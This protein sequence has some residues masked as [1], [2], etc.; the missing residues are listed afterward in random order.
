MFLT[1]SYYSNGS[2][3]HTFVILNVL[4]IIQHFRTKH[5]LQKLMLSNSIIIVDL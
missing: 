3:K 2:A 1:F 5:A 4:D